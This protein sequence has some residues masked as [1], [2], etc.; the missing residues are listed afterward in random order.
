MSPCGDQHVNGNGEILRN[1]STVN[2]MKIINTLLILI[3]S[4]RKTITNIP[5]LHV[6]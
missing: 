4:G 3:L 5:G 6:V 2:N 1:F